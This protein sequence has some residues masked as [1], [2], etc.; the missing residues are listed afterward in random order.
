MFSFYCFGLGLWNRELKQKQRISGQW[1]TGHW[2]LIRGLSKLDEGNTSYHE[3][4][5]NQG[6]FNRNI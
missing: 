6:M 2:L 1:E 4:D 5:D 3:E